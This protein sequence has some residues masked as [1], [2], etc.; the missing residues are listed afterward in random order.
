MES[1]EESAAEYRFP[2]CLSSLSLGHQKKP[3]DVQKGHHAE[4]IQ[5]FFSAFSRSFEPDGNM[6][7]EQSRST[8]QQG[9]VKR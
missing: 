9:E 4:E 5:S 8:V 7:S 6:P 1:L 3:S 2:N